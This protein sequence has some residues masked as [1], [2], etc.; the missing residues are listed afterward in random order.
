MTTAISPSARARRFLDGYS[1]VAG[2][3]AEPTAAE[4]QELGSALVKAIETLTDWPIRLEI[5]SLKREIV[6]FNPEHKELFRI[7]AAR[8]L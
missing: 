6:G 7:T 1:P 2:L 4:I 3:M 8:W 5:M